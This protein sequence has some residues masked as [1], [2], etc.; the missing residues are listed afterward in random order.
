MT[1][2]VGPSELDCEMKNYR[3]LVG[4]APANLS[5]TQSEQLGGR[6]VA[7]E[8]TGEDGTVIYRS[9][10]LE[11]HRGEKGSVAATD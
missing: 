10:L 7:G 8:I 5:V 1:C 3:V 2:T 11:M 4:D 6:D 9:E